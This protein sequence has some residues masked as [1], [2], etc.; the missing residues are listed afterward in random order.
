MTRTRSV[1][2]TT[3]LLPPM[4]N[5]RWRPSQEKQAGG[6]LSRTDCH[7]PLDCS[8]TDGWVDWHSPTSPWQ[9]EKWQSLGRQDRNFKS[10][11]CLA[12]HST[13]LLSVSSLW[14][15]PC[16]LSSHLSPLVQ[17][18]LSSQQYHHVTAVCLSG[19]ER[20]WL[21]GHLPPYAQ[22]SSICIIDVNTESQ[23]VLILERFQGKYC[24]VLR[25][26]KAVCKNRSPFV[27]V[28]S[29]AFLTGCG[30]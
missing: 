25:V 26:E 3:L 7:Q 27:R 21:R 4:T 11:H 1:G 12:N 29:F 14:Q 16:T 8:I 24:D 6:M 15:W 18:C 2:S 20:S 30:P 23:A 5:V 19:A 13:P 10:F 17:P 9:L 28:A 22:I